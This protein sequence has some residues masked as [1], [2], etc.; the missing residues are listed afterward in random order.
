MIT[1]SKEFISKCKCIYPNWEELHIALNN[2]REIVGRYLD[3]AR[4]GGISNDTI[5][6]AKTLE[7]LQAMAL[8]I[9]KKIDIYVEWGNL[10]YEKRGK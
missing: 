6:E 4:Y 5:L 9:K 3:D 1:Y 10:Y 2:N 7:S 8:E